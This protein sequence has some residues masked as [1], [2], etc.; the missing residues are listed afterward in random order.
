MQRI[1]IVIYYILLKIINR[2]VVEGIVL[3][4]AANQ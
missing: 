2:P 4:E 1:N 3:K